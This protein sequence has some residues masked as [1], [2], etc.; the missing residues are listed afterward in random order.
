MFDL[1]DTSFIFGRASIVCYFLQEFFKEK[2]ISLHEIWNADTA[3][4]LSGADIWYKAW[5]LHMKFN[6]QLCLGPHFVI[7]N[8]ANGVVYNRRKY[9]TETTTESIKGKKK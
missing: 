4:L 1:V 9:N 8:L 3:F 5:S 7:L 6:I 2:E